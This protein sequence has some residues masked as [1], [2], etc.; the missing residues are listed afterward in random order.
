MIINLNKVKIEIIPKKENYL[1]KIY[2]KKLTKKE[3]IL[4]YQS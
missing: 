3:Q 4:S 1:I 2:F